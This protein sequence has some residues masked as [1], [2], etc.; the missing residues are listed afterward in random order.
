[1][2]VAFMSKADIIG[3]AG[4]LGSSVMQMMA[5]ELMRE[6]APV[7]QS[8]TAIVE[9]LEILGETASDFVLVTEGGVIKGLDDLSGRGG[10]V[11]VC[12]VWW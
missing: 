2:C 9:V 5:G 7:C 10:V 4:R 6:Q 11:D 8:D 12:L 1:M 3:A